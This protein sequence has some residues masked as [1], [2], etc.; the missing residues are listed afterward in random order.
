MIVSSEDRMSFL[1]SLKA[2]VGTHACKAAEHTIRSREEPSAFCK[3][4]QT[5]KVSFS[6][7]CMEWFSKKSHSALFVESVQ[8]LS[9][10]ATL[11]KFKNAYRNRLILQ[12]KLLYRVY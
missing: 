6:V 10:H 2:E 7:V 8:F 12:G 1:H 11:L 4:K 3:T 9:S 5:N